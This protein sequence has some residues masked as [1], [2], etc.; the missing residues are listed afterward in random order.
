[1]W[2]GWGFRTDPLMVMCRLFQLSVNL[3]LLSSKSRNSAKECWPLSSLR[4][5]S[6]KERLL[7]N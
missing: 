6:T 5:G 4:T 7:L 2:F 3:A 1:M